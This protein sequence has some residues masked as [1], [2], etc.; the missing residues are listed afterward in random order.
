MNESPIDEIVALYQ[1]GVWWQESEHARAVLPKLILGRFFAWSRAADGKLV[2][3]GRAISDGVSDAC[4]Q[5]VVVLA[6]LRG[7]GIG[8]E[9]VARLTEYCLERH[10]EWIGLVAEPGTTPFYE[11]LG[12]GILE[13]SGAL[14]HR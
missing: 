13:G 10:L 12:F 8:H 1:A 3:M 14:R 7:R 9:L 6:E 2:G 4:I 11:K 5:D